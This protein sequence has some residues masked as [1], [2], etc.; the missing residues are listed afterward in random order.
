VPALLAE[1]GRELDALIRAVK[2]HVPQEQ[3]PALYE[4]FER[5]LAEAPSSG[6]GAATARAP[7]D[8]PN[9]PERDAA[10]HREER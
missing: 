6:N 7:R 8:A 10:A 3:G 9:H 4:E 1:L 2:N 5:R